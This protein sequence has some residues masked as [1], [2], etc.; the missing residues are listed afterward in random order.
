D[1]LLKKVATA[2]RAHIREQ[3]IP[4]RMGGDEFALLLPHCSATQAAAVLERIRQEIAQI[5]VDAAHPELCVSTS[6]GLTELFADEDLGIATK[7]ADEACYAAKH[8]GRNAVVQ[9]G[10]SV[11]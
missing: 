8:G 1:V 11:A 7:R 3:D 10:R 5:E 2:L 4:A 6:V 9:V